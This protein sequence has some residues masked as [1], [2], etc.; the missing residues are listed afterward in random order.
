M[1]SSVRHTVNPRKILRVPEFFSHFLDWRFRVK[2]TGAFF[3]GFVRGVFLV[4]TFSVGLN[5]KKKRVFSIF[6]IPNAI[7]VLDYF[8]VP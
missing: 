2:K 3:R 5:I 1:F 6:C 7:R 8:Q 4:F